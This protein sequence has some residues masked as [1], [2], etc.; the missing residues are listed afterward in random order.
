M[1]ENKKM[2]ALI[3]GGGPAG[4]TA[5]YELQTRSDI[6]PIIFEKLDGFGGISRTV[7]YKGNR[8]DIG[9]HRFFSKSDRVM[10]WWEKFM[11]IIPEELQG[12]TGSS[13]DNSSHSDNVMLIR[14]RFS[15][16]LYLGRLFDYPIKMNLKTIKYLGFNRIL[17]I[18]LSYAFVRLFPIKT[19]TN[20]EDFFINRFG[21]TLY[22]TFFKDYTEKIWGVPCNEIKSEWGAQRIKGLS[23]KKAISHA[24]KNKLS[25]IKD[26]QQKK[27][28]TSLIEKFLYPKFGPGQLWDCVADKY[29]EKKGQI[30]TSSEVVSIKWNSIESID[31]TVM[32]NLSGEKNTYKGNYLF[33][34]MPLKEL[35]GC[36][37]NDVPD[38]VREIAENLVYRDFI[39]VG[40]LLKKIKITG[41]YSSK[42]EDLPLDNWI[43]IQEKNVSIGRLQI[44]NNWS[45]YLVAEKDTVWVGLEYFCNEGD[46]LWSMGEEDF[47]HFA[48]AELVKLDMININDVLDSTIVKVPKAYPAYFGSY[49]EISVIQEY[50]NSLGNI[51]PIGR[52]G[53]HKYNNQDH[54]MLTAMISVD[55]ILS[56]DVIEKIDVWKVN[57]E[58]DY[59]EEIK[60]GKD[61]DN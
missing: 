15:R 29:I 8:M 46:N 40:L 9:G 33:S 56:K 23:F 49:D 41:K 11:P 44:F 26:I 17:G 47:R 20:L 13:S 61:I 51:F 60:D 59:H 6:E 27:I 32:N 14:N 2:T 21:K 58:M 28:E 37:E 34:T 55:N 19:E 7:N 35:I 22:Q 25:K 45:P 53:M 38:K 57:T 3:V 30:F 54:S 10:K 48:I 1:S 52:N 50:L 36:M 31:V 43:Y 42:E 18:S 24:I 4:L 16:I 12:T 39:T 5:G